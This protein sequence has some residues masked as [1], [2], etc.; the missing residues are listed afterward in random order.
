MRLA[1]LNGQRAELVRELQ[2]IATE[3][4]NKDMR[5]RS[6]QRV[7]FVEWNAYRRKLIARQAR[8]QSEI[9]ELNVER[10]R[11]SDEV[12]VANQTPA[13]IAVAARI[14]R[15]LVSIIDRIGGS[16]LTDTEVDILDEAAEFVASHDK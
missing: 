9:S 13:D 5:D 15:R 11:L 12:H 7:S 6:G 10:R 16:K 4:A 2:S 3:L 8:L 1:V 14:V